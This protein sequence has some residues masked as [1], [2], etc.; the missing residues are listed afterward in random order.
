MT[1][2]PELILEGV[3]TS[4]DI[5]APE[6]ATIAADELSNHVVADGAYPPKFIK[7]YAIDRDR[8]TAL[9]GDRVDESLQALADMPATIPMPSALEYRRKG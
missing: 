4:P 8:L 7:R 3:K 6:L 9:F 5:N 1:T 2:S